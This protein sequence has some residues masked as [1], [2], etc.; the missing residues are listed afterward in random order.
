MRPADSFMSH[1]YHVR[2]H[3]G[4]PRSLH[5]HPELP[6]ALC[7]CVS[8]VAPSIVEVPSEIPMDTTERNYNANVVSLFKFIWNDGGFSLTTGKCYGQVTGMSSI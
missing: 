4:L 1:C 7:V 8:C 2:L 6:G 5:V 3:V